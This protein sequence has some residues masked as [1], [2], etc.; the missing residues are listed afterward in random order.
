MREADPVTV[1]LD[2]ALLLCEFDVVDNSRR[3]TLEQRHGGSRKRS[4]GNERLQ[5]TGRQRAQPLRHE[6]AQALGQLDIR[7]VH[8]K[9]APDNRAPELEREERVTT[10]DF[11]HAHQLRSRQFERKPTPEEPMDRPDGQRLDG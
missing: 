11:V 3:H 2:D 10:C 4:D 7:A 9:R 5:D 8:A 6:G 1:E